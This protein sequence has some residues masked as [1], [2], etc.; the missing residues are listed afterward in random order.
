MYLR[1]YS[2]S[3]TFFFSSGGYSVFL[4]T[5][6]WYSLFRYVNCSPFW[7]STIRVESLYS[8]PT[9][10]SDSV[11]PNQYFSRPL[12]TAMTHTDAVFVRVV[13]PL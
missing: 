2:M 9:E 5:C 7:W 13:D 6:S 3:E 12:V 1:K 4:Q 11:Y 10:L 8:T